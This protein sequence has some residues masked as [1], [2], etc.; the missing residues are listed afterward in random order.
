MPGLCEEEEESDL[1]SVNLNEEWERLYE[2]Q[3]HQKSKRG[4]PAVW[5]SFNETRI[6]R[7]S[8]ET[9]NVKRTDTANAEPSKTSHRQHPADRGRGSSDHVQ[10]H[11]PQKATSHRSHSRS[12]S[13]PR[14]RSPSRRRQVVP[15][16]A[17]PPSSRKSRS[18]SRSTHTAAS[19]RT[20]VSVTT[21]AS[22][23]DKPDK[24][25]GND[26][27]A[28]GQGVRLFASRGLVGPRGP[29]KGWG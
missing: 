18:R 29:M 15:E 27:D 24:Q 1:D 7:H 21:R 8:R 10:K 19:V 28:H 25:Q 14:H 2:E 26:D 16:K 6:K 4:L 13:R 5:A 22:K 12:H 3:G 11:V 17:T 23:G 9:V 20:T